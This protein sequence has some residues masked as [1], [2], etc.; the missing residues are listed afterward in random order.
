MRA[1]H[2]V[3]DVNDLD[4]V[5]AFW[6]AL[7]DLAVTH[8]GPDW[9]DLSPLGGSAQGGPVLSFQLVPER[10]VVKNRLHIDIAVAPTGGGVVAAGHRA[11]ALGAQPASPLH[12]PDSN[13][14]QVWR[15]PEG[16]EFC[17]VTE[18]DVI[19]LASS[20]SVADDAGLAH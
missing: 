16:N 17:L 11:R 18:A 6:A 8:R 15:D 9:V 7:L 2:L 10:K 5:A 13:P 14:W 3:F 19:D 20:E 4:K 12:S 1:R